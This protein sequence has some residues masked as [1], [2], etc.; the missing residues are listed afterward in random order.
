MTPRD[1][2]PV[3][4]SAEPLP[5][6]GSARERLLAAQRM[7]REAMRGFNAASRRVQSEVERRDRAVAAI[8]VAIARANE[9]VDAT[10][11]ELVEVSGI[12]RTA[13]LTGLD[14]A[15]VRERLR[16]HRRQAE[17]SNA[18]G[19]SSAR[20]DDTTLES[21]AGRG[22]RTTTPPVGALSGEPADVVRQ[23]NDQSRPV[24]RRETVVSGHRD[25]VVED[26]ASG[27]Q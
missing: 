21:T 19:H 15:Q 17:A 7:E 23:R 27:G 11:A 26:N 14:V 8:Q 13:M 25:I 6:E 3:N 20:Q 18:N 22:D 2:V 1:S 9:R 12:G 10:L 24:D 4:G 16:D 5:V